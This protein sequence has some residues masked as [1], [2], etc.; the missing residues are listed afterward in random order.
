MFP[1]VS[2]ETRIITM[3]AYFLALNLVDRL[4]SNTVINDVDLMSEWKIFLADAC[5]RQR[6]NLGKICAATPTTASKAMI[7]VNR[8]F[9]KAKM[10][11][12]LFERVQF[13]DGVQRK[14]DNPFS[15]ISG[16]SE[17][18]TSET[19]AETMT[20]NEQTSVG[21]DQTR[22]N[23]IDQTTSP[24]STPR[25][26]QM[27]SSIIATNERT[28]N[29]DPIKTPSSIGSKAGREGRGGGKKK[30]KNRRRQVAEEDQNNGS[31][32]K[33][34][35][36]SRKKETK[37]I[38]SGKKSKKREKK[39]HPMESSEQNVQDGSEKE[40]VLKLNNEGGHQFL[41]MK[42]KAMET[43]EEEKSDIKTENKDA[44]S[45]QNVKQKLNKT[46]KKDS[47]KT[48]TEPET[49]GKARKKAKMMKVC[50]ISKYS[51]SSITRLV[52][53]Q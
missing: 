30:L 37:E 35:S 51:Y 10:G 4:H 14:D 5:E 40:T 53:V 25:S 48:A 23:N 19:D 3:L 29:K 26:S 2:E 36:P 31:V 24:N 43:N 17:R 1:T 27:S 9:R 42:N 11:E 16:N 41:S 39:Q 20:T 7:R 34:A 12:I 6:N 18:T 52:I 21:Y 28:E 47:V 46:T 44:F 49:K 32:T 15:I 50:E 8:L 13:V 45:E 38:L 33:S 22:S